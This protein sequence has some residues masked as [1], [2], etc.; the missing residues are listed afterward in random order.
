VKLWIGIAIA[1]VL[2]LVGL[3][4]LTIGL[5]VVVQQLRARRVN[6]LHRAKRLEEVRQLPNRSTVVMTASQRPTMPAMAAPRP[7]SPPSPTG[8]PTLAPEDEPD[9]PTAVFRPSQYKDIEAML[10]D[11]DNHAAKHKRK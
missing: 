8:N 2:L 4:G 10:K 9:V 11:A 1:C 5:F 3:L 7:Q 6:Q